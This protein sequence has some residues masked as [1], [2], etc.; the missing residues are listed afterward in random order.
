MSA[1]PVA[2]KPPSPDVAALPVA[3]TEPP[4]V[5]APPALIAPPRADVLFSK[6]ESRFSSVSSAPI[7]T[8]VPAINAPFAFPETLA[9]PP[10]VIE[11]DDMIAPEF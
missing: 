9:P 2:R 3:T 8:V 11:L 6:S 5:T 7:E 1:P 4:N 10:T